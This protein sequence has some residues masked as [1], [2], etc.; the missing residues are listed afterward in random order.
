MGKYRKYVYICT[1]IIQEGTIQS[2]LF[3]IGYSMEWKQNIE[4]RLANIFAEPENQDL[5]L[6]DIAYNA[7]NNKLEIFLE[8]DEGLSIGRCARINRNLQELIDE[9]LWFGEKYTL[10]VSSP[11]IGKPLILLRQYRKNI[12]RT[13]EIWKHEGKPV[14]GELLDAKETEIQIQ[15]EIGKKKNK[16]T[17]QET[18]PFEN[19]KRAIVK[20]SF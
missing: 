1:Q 3:C 19:I 12:G 8:G 17:V 11:G 16:E 15:F 14:Q 20:V 7:N 10:D 9:H 18:I 6:V 4:E 2:P 5:F 13:L